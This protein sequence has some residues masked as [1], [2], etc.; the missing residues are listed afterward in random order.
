MSELLLTTPV[1]IAPRDRHIVIF[2]YQDARQFELQC[3]SLQY[4]ISL[5]CVSYRKQQD[6]KTTV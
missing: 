2:R 3:C 5:E 4:I 1:R 6:E